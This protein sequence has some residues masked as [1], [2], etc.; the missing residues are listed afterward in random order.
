[1]YSERSSAKGPQRIIYQGKE[2]FFQGY[3]Q[4][5]NFSR[6]Y[7]ERE[8]GAG[9]G[10]NAS[11]IEHYTEPFHRFVQ[12]EGFEPQANEIP[13]TMPSWLPGDDYMTNFKVGDPYVRIDDGYARLLRS[14]I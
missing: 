8:L 5:D 1:M 9:I 4:M 2:V 3:R 12:S 11:F 6:S 10:P 13:N 14:W 7:Y